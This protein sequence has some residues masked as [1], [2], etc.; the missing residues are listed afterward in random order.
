MEAEEHV[1]QE[2]GPPNSW[3][4]DTNRCREPTSDRLAPSGRLIIRFMTARKE[5]PTVAQFGQSTFLSYVH[6]A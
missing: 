5:L 3:H 4:S 2:L 6:A 1:Q